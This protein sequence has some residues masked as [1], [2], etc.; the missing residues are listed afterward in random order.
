MHNISSILHKYNNFLGFVESWQWFVETTFFLQ[1]VKN[2]WKTLLNWYSRHYF[3][4]YAP[5]IKS[6]FSKVSS[7]SS[8]PHMVTHTSSLKEPQWQATQ[9]DLLFIWNEPLGKHVTRHT[10]PGQRLKWTRTEKGG[11]GRGGVAFR[12]NENSGLFQP[13]FI[14]SLP[15]C[16]IGKAQRRIA[17]ADIHEKLRTIEFAWIFTKSHRIIQWQQMDWILPNW[18]CIKWIR[19]RTKIKTTF[20]LAHMEPDSL[21][22]DEGSRFVSAQPSSGLWSC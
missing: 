8:M 20:S 17:V 21:A 4:G 14:H 2:K 10:G 22:V 12:G 9:R 6:T 11:F 7:L 15:F 16:Q 18:I 5:W 3:W 19:Q 1:F 13:F